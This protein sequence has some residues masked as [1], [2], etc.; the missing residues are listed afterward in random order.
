MVQCLKDC[1]PSPNPLYKNKNKKIKN[2]KSG[3]MVCTHD[4]GTGETETNRRLPGSLQSV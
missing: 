3:V 2:I 1:A 4:L